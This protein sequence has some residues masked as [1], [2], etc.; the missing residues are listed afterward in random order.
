MEPKISATLLIIIVLLG[1]SA[2]TAVYAQI[3]TP[4]QP[5]TDIVKPYKL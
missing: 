1:V 2:N 4:Q 3:I 5:T